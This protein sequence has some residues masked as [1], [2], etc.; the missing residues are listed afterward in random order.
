M[1]ILTNFENEEIINR[2]NIYFEQADYLS[3][4]VYSREENVKKLLKSIHSLCFYTEG[5]EYLIPNITVFIR[6]GVSY[7]KLGKY[8]DAIKNFKIV[9]LILKNIVD[10]KKEFSRAKD[11]ISRFYY[12]VFLEFNN[13]NTDIIYELYSYIAYTQYELHNPIFSFYSYQQALKYYPKKDINYLVLAIG[14]A[15]CYYEIFKIFITF[16]KILFYAICFGFVCCKYWNNIYVMSVNIF[17]LFDN[18]YW[19]ILIGILILTFPKLLYKLFYFLLRRI[20][21]YIADNFVRLFPRPFE[22][23]LKE[24]LNWI[25]L[26]KIFPYKYYLKIIKEVEELGHKNFDTFFAIA[27]LYYFLGDY[28]IST[29]YIQEALKNININENIKYALASHYLARIA[30]KQHNHQTAIKFYDNT[31]EYLIK[32]EENEKAEKNWFVKIIDVFNHS[33]ISIK[34][35]IHPIPKIRDIIQYSQENK[36]ILDKTTFSRTYLPLI[37]T[38]IITII[39]SI[40]DIY[41][42][43]PEHHLQVDNFFRNNIE[44]INKLFLFDDSI[45]DSNN[46]TKKH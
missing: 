32:S 3:L 20:R 19:Y 4:I 21:K 11:K 17:R 29:F 14:K 10:L 16:I 2:I 22:Q 8:K 7:Y 25:N 1:D 37:I 35:T 39:I 24:F 28:S 41:T 34:T 46:S 30:Y 6:I 27:K 33:R 5:I 23:W 12:D 13:K 43:I 31:I 15:D 42:N 26:K 9:Q 44:F 18:I 40:F 36:D 45:I 38:L